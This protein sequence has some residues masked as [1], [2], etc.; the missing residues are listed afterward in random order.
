MNVSTYLLAALATFCATAATQSNA[1][2]GLDGNLY[3]ISAPTYW[4]RQGSPYPNG[5]IGFSAANYMCNSGSVDI[6]WQAAMAEDHPMFGFMVTRLADDRMVQISDRSFCKHAFTSI[7]GNQGPCTPCQNPNNGSLMGIGC[8]DVYSA[9]NNAD[10]FWLGPADEINPWLGTWTAVGSYF[11][12]GDPNV[13]AP[14]NSDGARSLTSSMTTTGAMGPVKNRVTLQ[15]QDLEWPNADYFYMVHLLHRGEPV[16]NRG[17]NLLTRQLS[18][19][20]TGSS[21]NESNVAPAQTGSPLNQWPGAQVNLAGNGTD[22]GRIAVAVKVTPT[23]GGMYHYEYAVH[24]IDNHRGAASFRIPVC[25]AAEIQNLGFRDIDADSLN[26]WT[27]TVSSGEI[28]FTAPANNPLKW[29]MMFNFWFDSD[30][31]PVAGDATFDQALIGPGALSFTVPTEFPGDM[32]TVN[33]GP[34][35]GTPVVNLG[36]NSSP[37]IPNSSFALVIDTAPFTGVFLFYGFTPTNQ[38]LG[39]GC[40]QFLDS[41]TI[42]TGGFFLTSLSGTQNIPLPIPPG[43]GPIDL[44]FQ[45]AA[46]APGGPALGSFSLSNGLQVRVGSNGCP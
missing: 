14:Q 16:A 18:L 4:G 21:W 19:S 25:D 40:T 31:A 22:D 12:Q 33:M 2:S 43:V 38:A 7:N 44:Y 3:N 17:N 20:W 10:R 29:N 28:A 27:A 5:E 36:A 37:T 26:E 45:A 34:G 41:T 9:G 24:N 46:L 23:T 35:C 39:N 6:V 11:D 15:E 42:G 8:Y 13:G 1:I 32:P 30:A